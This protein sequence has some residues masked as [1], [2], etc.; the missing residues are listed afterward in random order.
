MK[1]KFAIADLLGRVTTKWWL[2]LSILFSLLTIYSVT[3][4]G[5]MAIAGLS[6]ITIGLPVLIACM[7]NLKFGI[8]I[9]LVISYFILGI[10]RFIEIPLGLLMDI[11]IGSMFFGL[12]IKQIRTRDWSLASNVITIMIL[13]WLSYCV[14]EVFNPWAASKLAWMYTIRS[15]A[16]LMLIYFV[17]L[18]AFDDIKFLRLFLYVWIGLSLL[19]AIYGLYQEFVGLHP[20]ELKWINADKQRF[21]LFF[22]W[23]RYRK[24]SYFSNPTI[25]GILMAHS[26]L[27]CIVLATGVKNLPKK[28]FLIIS[29]VIMLWSMIYSGTRTATA[30]IPAGLFFFVLLTFQRKIIITSFIF[31]L[32]GLF[33]ILAPIDS[34]GPINKNNLERIRST[35]EFE[36]DPSFKARLK[37]QAFIQPF[38]WSHPMG[39]GL[40]SVGVWGRRFSPNSPIARFPPDSGFVRVAVELGWIG[41]IIY[42]GL[43]FSIMYT[44]IKNYYKCQSPE[45]KLYYAA[46][47]T[48]TYSLIVANYA[49]QAVT[50]FPTMTIF[51]IL[52]ALM[53]VLKKF[54]Q[55]PHP[56]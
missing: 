55:S 4:F 56:L 25:F 7:F 13:V 20:I 48:V 44:G 31:F 37:N 3:K 30:M 38:I 14:L 39:G 45:I 11:L 51:Y 52:M 28:I 19:A 35:F 9:L 8:I 54:D 16:L 17:A 40:G 22:N 36:D 47:L 18:Y 46:L 21:K 41:L 29:A 12:V 2:G 43:L 34:F 50:M 6:T 24:F 23:G 33:L 27:L 49:Q 1:D 32:F 5:M 42:C 10:L 15:M 26:G 53:I